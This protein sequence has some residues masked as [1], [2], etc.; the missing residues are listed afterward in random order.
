MDMIKQI[1]NIFEESISLQNKT[2]EELS[3]KIMEAGKLLSQSLNQGNKI[4]VCG[5]GGSA[6]DAQHFSSELV[7]K[8]EKDRRAL[9]AI[10]LTTDS[11]TITS[12]ANDSNYNEVFSRQI[13]ALSKPG[14]IL[15]AIS[16]SG[17]SLNI[18]SAVNAA[19]ESSMGVIALTGNKGG[20]IPKILSSSDIELRV[21]SDSTARIQEVHA[22]I[23]HCL[24][25]LVDNLVT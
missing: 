12:I 2:C 9:A 25:S 8:F 10:A 13:A 4:L 3:S 16:T 20:E 6:S 22:V 7:N 15:I 14:D 19:H 23:I 1:E 17:N 24:C 5:N 21:A 18:I 11:S